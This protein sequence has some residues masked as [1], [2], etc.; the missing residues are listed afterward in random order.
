[1]SVGGWTEVFP[2]TPLALL[3]F[4]AGLYAA[5]ATTGDAAALATHRFLPFFCGLIVLACDAKPAGMH[6]V[7]ALLLSAR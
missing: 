4:V 7:S 2:R 5:A 3:A 1:M 6:P